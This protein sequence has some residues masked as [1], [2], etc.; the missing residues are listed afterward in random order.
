MTDILVV[1]LSLSSPSST[2][3]FLFEMEIENGGFRGDGKTGE[4]GEKSLGKFLPSAFEPRSHT[5]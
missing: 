4:L 5:R 3:P 1:T 2:I